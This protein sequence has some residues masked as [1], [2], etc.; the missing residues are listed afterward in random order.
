MPLNP[1]LPGKATQQL[2]SITSDEPRV[3]L[4]TLAIGNSIISSAPAFF[5]LGI[6]TLIPLFCATVS[7]AQYSVSSPNNWEMVGAFIEGSTSRTLLR[8]ALGTFIFMRTLPR[9]S[10]APRSRVTKSLIYWRFSGS[11]QLSTFAIN[12]VLDSTMVST[13]FKRLA[14]RLDPLS[15]NS[16]ATSAISGIFASVVPKE[17]SI[18]TGIPSLLKYSLEI[19]TY[20]VV[21]LLPGL[22]SS[23]VFMSENSETATTIRTGRLVRLLYASFVTLRTLSLQPRSKTQ[24]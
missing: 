6:N 18:F 20:S 9:A 17:K 11:C 2:F 13:I 14:R 23:G 8:E 4:I 5:N 7:T 22:I 3:Y 19:S 24:S 15:V 10:R 12:M 21:T 1:L 16:T